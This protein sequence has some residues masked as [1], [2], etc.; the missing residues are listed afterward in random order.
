MTYMNWSDVLTRG[1]AD[2]TL[3]FARRTWTQPGKFA[4]VAPPSMVVAPTGE[5]YPLCATV[6]FKDFD[7]VAKPYY[8]S[9]NAMTEAHDWYVGI[10]GQ[11]PE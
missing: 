9:M 11:P 5:R 10:S 8:P 6:Y 4:W 7:G 3:T 1:A 2:P